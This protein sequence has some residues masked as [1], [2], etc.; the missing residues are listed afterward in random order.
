MSLSI[1]QRDLIDDLNLIGDP[2][3][4]LSAVVARSASCRLPDEM[5]TDANR[6]PGCVS[7]VWVVGA[8]EP[9]GCRFRCDAD[10]PL[11]KGLVALLCDLYTGGS[12]ADVVGTE[13]AVWDGCG[14][15]RLLSPTRLNGLRSV[16]ARIREL[17]RGFESADAPEPEPKPGPGA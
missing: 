4:R 1:R 10:S 7:A 13:P 9:T 12:P 3:E 14:L 2:H 16:R 17:A 8:L 5:K 6:V 11:V 15:S